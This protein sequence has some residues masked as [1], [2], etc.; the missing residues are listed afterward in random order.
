[1]SSEIFDSYLNKINQA[2]LRGDATEHTHRPALKVLVEALG[3]K[4]TATNEP[5]WVECGAPDNRLFT[6]IKF[7]QGIVIIR[8]LL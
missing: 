6:E 7:K 2:Y 1:M 3:K 8:K 5:K 4:V